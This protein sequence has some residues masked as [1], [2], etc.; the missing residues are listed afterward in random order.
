MSGRWSAFLGGLVEG[1]RKSHGQGFRSTI[2]EIRERSQGI[3]SLPSYRRLGSVRND[4][5][6]DGL[7]RLG[8]IALVAERSSKREAHAEP[9]GQ[10]L[11]ALDFGGHLRESRLDGG[12]RDA[13]TREVDGNGAVSQMSRGQDPSALA[14]SARV[15]QEAGIAEVL[16]DRRRFLGP[17]S[18]ARQS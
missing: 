4:L 12:R 1:A 2:R 14:R 13:S 7:D 11:G 9:V 6:Q 18:C 16:D 17:D 5:A 8:R 15:A 10:G 3:E